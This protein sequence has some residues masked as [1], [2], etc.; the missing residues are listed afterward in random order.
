[1]PSSD[2]K[3]APEFKYPPVQADRSL[4][5]LDLSTL[6]MKSTTRRLPEQPG[7]SLDDSTYELLTD[8]LIETSDD[9][10]HTESIASTSDAPTPD[11]ASAFSDDDDDF[12]NGGRALDES[13]QSMHAAAVAADDDLE[14][15]LSAGGADSMLTMV[16]DHMDGSAGSSMIQLDEELTEDAD[17]SLGTTIIKT[18]PAQTEELPKILERYGQAQ[19]RLVVKAA[20]SPRCV[21]TPESYKILYLGLP[22]RWVQD[23]ITSQIH[24]ALTASPSNTRSVMVRGQMEP[25][26]P[27]IHAFRCSQLQIHD[28]GAALPEVVVK[29]DDGRQL[30]LG[31][32]KTA[33]FDLVVHCHT[34][35]DSYADPQTFDSL[36]AAL[37][38]HKVPT[39]ELSEIRPYGAGARTYDMRSLSVCIEGRSDNEADFKLLEVLPLDAFTFCELEP[40]QVNRHL[41]LISPHL[42]PTEVGVAPK[43]RLASVVDILRAMG[44]QLRTGAPATTKVLLLSIALTAMLSAFV[45]SPIYMPLLLDKSTATAAEPSYLS[46][47]PV[48]SPVVTTPAVSSLKVASVMSVSSWSLSVPKGPSVIAPPAKQPKPKQEKNNKDEGVSGF[49]MQ[50]AGSNQFVLTPSK[51]LASSRKKPQ[52][53]IQVFRNATL[54]PIRYVRII[55]GEY[56]VDL[57]DEYPFGSFNVSIA[58]YSKPLLRQSFEVNLGH[59]KTWF[60]QVLETTANKVVGA[61]SLFLNISSTTAEQLQ[62]KLVDV[63]GPNL[64]RWV[65]EGRQLEQAAYRSTK[66]GLESGTKFIKHVPGATW[67]GLRRAT[68]PVR[69]SQTM[70]KARMNAL[71]LR[72]SMEKAVGSW[73]K[74][75]NEMQ[76]QACLQS[77]PHAHEK[78]V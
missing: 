33:Q 63:A 29:T 44:K 26:G 60:D 40:L 53:Q 76:S 30:R 71:R 4:T 49:D 5:S 34:K 42:V 69:L 22:E 58:S 16:P 35:R 12:E 19:I 74:G 1:M 8:S 68:A 23:S 36:R 18:L 64:G 25:L 9:E 59:N 37:R 70:W 13:I 48:S 66:E 41:A 24:A 56:F 62:A 46:V 3:A 17:A 51:D 2:P 28:N 20:L 54:V 65:E 78:E 38:R 32:R 61:Q 45:L 11:D 15:P 73:R 77:Q 52:L 67:L 21:P 72:C 10:A 57:E 75:L 6:M 55:T 31:P 14:T 7:S 47:T 27:V 39:I 50:T 43:G